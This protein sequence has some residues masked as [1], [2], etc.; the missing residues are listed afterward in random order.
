MG[1]P[2][3][4]DC[5]LGGINMKKMI[6]I[7]FFCILISGCEQNPETLKNRE[8]EKN[9]EKET[10]EY[11]KLPETEEIKEVGIKENPEEEIEKEEVEGIINSPETPCGAED[12]EEE[13]DDSYVPNI[14]NYFEGDSFNLE[15]YLRD[16]EAES[17]K[18]T[19]EGCTSVFYDWKI[20][21]HSKTWSEIPE[22]SIE[23][24]LNGKKYYFDPAGDPNIGNFYYV[25]EDILICEA[26]IRKLPDLLNAFYDNGF[27]FEPPVIYGLIIN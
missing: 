11:A 8:P 9:T 12:P 13:I 3:K 17:I 18:I 16:C 1:L 7:L 6:M 14:D 27:A 26:S 10:I 4:T 5:T 23:N 22:F 2:L 25:G 24:E 21:I 15:Q 19:S 20:E